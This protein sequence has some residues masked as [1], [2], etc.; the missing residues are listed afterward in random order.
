M[1]ESKPR[2]T[3]VQRSQELDNL[4]TDHIVSQSSADWT[5]VHLSDGNLNLNAFLKSYLFLRRAESERGNRLLVISCRVV[6]AARPSR[7][8]TEPF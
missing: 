8:T 6:I 1:L 5:P 3:I 2:A 7:F 4:K